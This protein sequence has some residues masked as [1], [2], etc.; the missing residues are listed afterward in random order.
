MGTSGD[1]PSA[2]PHPDD[3]VRYVAL[4]GKSLPIDQIGQWVTNT[5]RYEPD[6]TQ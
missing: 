6:H 1:G 3:A 2:S 5:L 4:W